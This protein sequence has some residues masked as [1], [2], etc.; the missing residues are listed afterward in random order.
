MSDLEEAAVAVRLDVWGGLGNRLFML[1]AGVVQA[2]ALRRPLE[3]VWGSGG[4]TESDLFEGLDQGALFAGLET[5]PRIVPPRTDQPTLVR[6]TY[7]RA[8]SAALSRVPFL[9]EKTDGGRRATR[10]VNGSPV[11]HMRGYFQDSS[12]V[13]RAMAVGWPAEV[14]LDERAMT[15]AQRVRSGLAENYVAI[16]V[17]MGDYALP[18]NQRRLGAPDANYY[19]HALALARQA[20]QLSGVPLVIFSDCPDAAVS[21]LGQAGIRADSVVGP[22]DTQ[23]ASEAL[24][25]MSQAD[26]LVLS[27]STFSWWGARWRIRSGPVVCPSPWHDRVN[28]E[29]LADSDWLRMQKRGLSAP[30]RSIDGGSLC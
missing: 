21:F 28:S 2:R 14:P 16:H 22:S 1:A 9:I 8:R 5:L 13:R 18:A 25:L 10:R 6:K 17:R 7:D 20:D 23:C 3:V 19:G 12:I 29:A 15:S 30:Q 24:W 27:N 26:G 4:Q 11:L